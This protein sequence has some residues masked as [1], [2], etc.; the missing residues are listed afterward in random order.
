MKLRKITSLTMLLSFLLL[1]VTAIV[2]YV[3][4]EGRVAYW[5]PTGDSWDLVKPFGGIFTSILGFYSFWPGC[6]TFIT[7]G[8]PS[9]PI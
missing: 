8:R 7:T 2:L 4:P 9:S 1:I 5:P 3:V 6:C